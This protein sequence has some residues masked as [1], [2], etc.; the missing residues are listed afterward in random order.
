MQRPS[1]LRQ[2]AAQG[3]SRCQQT[4][5]WRCASLTWQRG[6][7]QTARAG[8]GMTWTVSQ[9]QVRGLHALIVMASMVRC[10]QPQALILCAVDRAISQPAQ[11]VSLFGNDDSEIDS[12]L[13]ADTLTMPGDWKKELRQHQKELEV[14]KKVLYIWM[15]TAAQSCPFKRQLQ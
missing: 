8:L 11:L 6:S 13:A 15:R 4:I 2:T 1:G 9:S 3:F 14:K 5:L 12:D 7:K 10:L